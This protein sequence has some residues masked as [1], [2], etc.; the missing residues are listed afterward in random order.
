MAPR[1]ETEAR[2]WSSNVLDIL[3]GRVSTLLIASIALALGI[4]SFAVLA[5]RIKMNVHSGAAVSSGT[6]ISL[7]IRW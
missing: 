2:S 1:R 4:A 7:R 6:S 3:L 5:G